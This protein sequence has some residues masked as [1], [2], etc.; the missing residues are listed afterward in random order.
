MFDAF[1]IAPGCLDFLGWSTTHFA[2]RWLSAR[3]RAGWPEGVKRAFRSAGASLAD[4]KWDV[5]D[6][7][8][9]ASWKVNKT[10]AGDPTHDFWWVDDNPSQDD[11]D[12]LRRYDRFDRLIEASSDLDPTALHAAKLLLTNRAPANPGLFRSS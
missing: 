9:S 12:W 1:D 11:R 3:C 5:L 2:C 7:I 10:E 4:P 8:H 6:L